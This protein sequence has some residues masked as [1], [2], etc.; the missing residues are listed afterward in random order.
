MSTITIAPARPARENTLVYTA[1]V[2]IAGVLATTLAQPQV[3]AR[4]P[5]QNL[6][7]NELHMDRSANAAFMFLSGLPWYFKPFAGI[8]TDAFPLF[9]SRRRSYLLVS[10]GL[11][12]AAWALLIVTPHDYNKLLWVCIAINTFTV[13]ASCVV[14][15]YMVEA[16]Q[17]TA[18]SGRLTAMRELVQQTCV[19][20]RGPLAGYLASIAFGWTAATS[21]GI[22]FLLIPATLLFMRER[23]TRIDSRQLIANAGKQ[24]VAIAGAR[25]MWAAAGLALLFYIAPGFSTAVFYIQQNDFHMTTEGQGGLGLIAGVAGIV[26]AFTY[27][28][29]CRRYNLRTLLI[30]CLA[31]AT[32][33]NFGYLFY[34]SVANARLITAFEGF[35]YTLAELAMMD[36]AIRA[37]P[38]GSEGLGFSLMMSVR[39]LALFGTDWLGSLLLDRF[40]L[41]FNDLVIANGATTAIT[42]PLVLLLPRVLV[43]RRDAEI[44]E[45]AAE[46][47]IAP[48]A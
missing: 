19:I 36:L 15:A 24:L 39:N 37:T 16:A 25:T 48:Q 4:L 29:A 46:T 6:I 9:G 45:E 13:T 3:L 10:T 44:Y 26:A 34:S 23:R 14:G 28:L 1:I 8:L 31:L 40:H 32:I 5:L 35:G 38:P 7:K 43:R 22:M 30:V 11:A 21:G 20:I 33:S 12:V 47:R 17:A 27:G 2:I 42:V 41:P 18:A